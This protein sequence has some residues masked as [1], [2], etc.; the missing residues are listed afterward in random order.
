MTFDRDDWA[1]I[2]TRLE[3]ATHFLAQAR[4]NSAKKDTLLFYAVISLWTFGE[5]AINVVLELCDPQAKP[6]QNHGQADSA[7]ALSV[8]GHLQKDYS[9]KLGQLER[10]RKKSS[11]K[12]YARER[13]VHFSTQTSRTALMR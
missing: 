5:Y 6:D 3:T 1:D 10:Y 12:G 4:A 8:A 7:E 9:I 2:V 11:H 13:T